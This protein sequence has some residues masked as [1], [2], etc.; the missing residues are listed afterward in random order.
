MASGSIR[1]FRGFLTSFWRFRVSCLPLRLLP[2][3]DLPF[4][5]H[6][7]PL[8]LSMCPIFGKTFAITGFDGKEEEYVTAAKAIGMGDGRILPS[9]RP[10]E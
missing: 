6:L 3:W 9:P 8:Q 1:S 7:S 5:T 10:S 2:F 4:A